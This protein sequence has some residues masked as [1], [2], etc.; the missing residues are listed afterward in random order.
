M[1]AFGHATSSHMHHPRPEALLLASYQ[2]PQATRQHP[3]TPYGLIFEP[4]LGRKSP[5][6]WA[7]NLRILR[8]CL[9]L[10]GLR[11]TTTL[12]GAPWLHAASHVAKC[13]VTCS[14]NAETTIPTVR[15][16]NRL[17]SRP[18]HRI[19]AMQCWV[20]MQYVVQIR[21]YPHA[22]LDNCFY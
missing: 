8:Q 5:S 9:V 7:K 17:R 13:M 22:G 14:T 18:G 1:S 20:V 3:I 2:R 11:A 19:S 10:G 15:S 6:D 16:L 12:R 21:A 4:I